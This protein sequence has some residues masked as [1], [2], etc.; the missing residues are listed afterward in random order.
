ME[1]GFTL[2]ELLVVVIIIGVLSAVALP[3]FLSQAARARQSEAE[4]TLGALN[5]AQQVYRLENP[6]FGQ[7]TDLQTAG[8]VSISVPGDYYNYVDVANGPAAAQINAEALSAPKDYTADIRN[9]QAGV[10]QDST[11]GAFSSVICRSPNPT[12][13]TAAAA[14]DALSCSV[15]DEVGG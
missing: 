4:V 6:D 9:Y 14:A 2:I 1:G 12:T 7:I 10:A 3:Q 5:R 15:G 11:T 13:D 8:S